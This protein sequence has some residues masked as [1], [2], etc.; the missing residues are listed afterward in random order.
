MTDDAPHTK[1]SKKKQPT[2][3]NRQ[4]KPSSENASML[5]LLSS[6]HETLESMNL[7]GIIV[8]MSGDCDDDNKQP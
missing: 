2:N 6:S 5:H 1:L 7:N 3:Q 8:D 4:N